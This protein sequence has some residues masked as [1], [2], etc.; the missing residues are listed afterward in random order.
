M[1]IVYQ[2]TFAFKYMYDF[3]NEIHVFGK[4]YILTYLLFMYMYIHFKSLMI[5]V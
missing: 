2:I 3:E 1:I 5:Y 4:Q